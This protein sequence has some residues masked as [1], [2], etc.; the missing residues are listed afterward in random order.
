MTFP[1][2]FIVEAIVAAFEVDQLTINVATLSMEDMHT[3]FLGEE[4]SG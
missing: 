4:G 1:P 2:T 3:L